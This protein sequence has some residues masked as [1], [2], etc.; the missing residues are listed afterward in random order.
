L[1]GS[2]SP[3]RRGFR[4]GCSR[5]EKD[6]SILRFRGMGSRVQDPASVSGFMGAR[7]RDYPIKT[8]FMGYKI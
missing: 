1:T 6:L 8:E 2:S 4:K 7:R 5:V 3:K